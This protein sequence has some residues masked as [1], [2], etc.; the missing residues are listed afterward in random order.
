MKSWSDIWW[1]VSDRFYPRLRALSEEAEKR[2]EEFILTERSKC[3]EQ[4][5]ALP[6]EENIL[7][8][9][10]D[11]CIALLR[12][13]Q[14]VRQS[15]E[16]RLTSTMGLTTIAGTIAVGGILA[17]ASGTQHITIAQRIIVSLGGLYLVSQVCWVIRFSVGGLERRGHI[18]SNA[19]DVLPL[20][21]EPRPAYLR[22]QISDCAESLADFRS[23]RKKRVEQMALAHCAIK[24]FLWGLVSF[25]VLGTIF[26][27]TTT[28]TADDLTQTLKKNREL[29][30][31]LRGP[32]GPKGDPGPP[33]PKGD[34]GPPSATGAGSRKSQ[35]SG[36]TRR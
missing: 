24:N 14:E 33:G 23:V 28:N 27:I 31:Q 36:A 10:V 30:E 32:Q 21:S 11:E 1:F 4:I 9:C 2:E 35:L 12:R 5:K 16:A 20:P 8:K 17:L 13:E 25:A 6:N 3:E 7:S 29:Y 22:R 34:P 26:A 15:I 18:E 19:S